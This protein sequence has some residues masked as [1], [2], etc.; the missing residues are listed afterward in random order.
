MMAYTC[1][2]CGCDT[3]W[4]D[5]LVEAFSEK[6]VVCDQCC[7]DYQ[8]S[9]KSHK[10]EIVHQ[11][12]PITELIRP[13]Y[14]ETDYEKL[15]EEAQNVWNNIKHWTPDIGKGIY[16][17][18]ASRTGKS[19]LLTLLLQKL[20]G[21]GYAF[22]IFYAGEFHAELSNAKR[23]T[24]YRSWRDEVVTIPILA[25]D[26]LFAEKMT[27]TSEAGLFE[28]INQRMERKLPV[29]ATSQVIRKDAVARFDDKHR[30]E[31]LLNRLRETTQ[32]WL[33]N[34]EL[35]QTTMNNL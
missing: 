18:G 14:L 9:K 7:E 11:A 34:Q 6:A 20:H 31:A 3:D 12:R 27:P 33:F 17:L 19:R 28:I 5:E 8:K 1:R 30:G 22:K 23:S 21:Y 13:L 29:L 15:P 35:M 32:L 10:A 26:D 25:I 4:T 16:L 2:E 24:H